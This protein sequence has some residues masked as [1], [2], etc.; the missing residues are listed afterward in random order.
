MKTINVTFTKEEYELLLAVKVETTWHDFIMNFV[1]PK[2]K[3]ENEG[4]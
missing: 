2:K 4:K 3:K 1:T